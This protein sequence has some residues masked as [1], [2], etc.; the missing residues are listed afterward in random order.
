MRHTASILT[1]G[2][3]GTVREAE[4]AV[5]VEVMRR[6]VGGA[7]SV[8]QHLKRLYYEDLTRRGVR[9]VAEECQVSDS[10]TIVPA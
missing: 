4:G 1:A 8:R 9:T 7:G 5:L 3:S 10:G 6:I 2:E